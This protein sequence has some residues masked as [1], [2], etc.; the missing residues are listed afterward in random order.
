M[1]GGLHVWTAANPSRTNTY[2]E[3][4]A[5]QSQAFANSIRKPSLARRSRVGR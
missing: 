1:S 3:S 5:V 4:A 2:A